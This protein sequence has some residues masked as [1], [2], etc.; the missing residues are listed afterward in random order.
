[1]RGV[2][3]AVAT[4][5]VIQHAIRPARAL[6]RHSRLARAVALAASAT[7]CLIAAPPAAA[8]AASYT[9]TDLGSLGY[10]VT[11]ALG[12]NSS[13]QK[14]GQTSTYARHGFLWSNG[15]MTDLGNNFF[16]AAIND[17]GVIVGGPFVSSGGS[18]Q[19]LNALVPAGSP[20]NIMHA[21]GINDSGQIVAD[22]Y[23]T[24]TNQ[25]HAVVLSPNGGAH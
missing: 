8:A 16:A 22:A 14:T 24:A 19:D 2:A 5:S 18:L 15:T 12:I 11:R 4:Q 3:G 6:G 9:I 17:T 1:M 20:Y 13:G 25:G 23:D 21:R 7:A 10:G